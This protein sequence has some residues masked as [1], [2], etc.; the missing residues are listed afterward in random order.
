MQKSV[1]HECQKLSTFEQVGTE[2][3][4]QNR[5]GRDLAESVMLS[6]AFRTSWVME[7]LHDKSTLFQTQTFLHLIDVDM[8]ANEKSQI[9]TRYKSA[10]VHKVPLGDAAMLYLARARERLMS[11]ET[12]VARCNTF[13]PSQ[14][15]TK[16]EKQKDKRDKFPASYV[17]KA[18]QLADITQKKAG[19]A[20]L[21]CKNKYTKKSALHIRNSALW[22]H[23]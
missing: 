2:F 22:G 17:T 8:N 4:M 11:H 19:R 1:L 20:Y 12:Q 10:T 21:Q 6:P 18:Y 3:L 16:D 9:G 5:R 14:T 15:I 13:V 7:N 23:P